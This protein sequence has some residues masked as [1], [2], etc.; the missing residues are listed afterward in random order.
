MGVFKGCKLTSFN[1]SSVAIHRHRHKSKIQ[2]TNTNTNIAARDIMM[3]D[4]E[5]TI[6]HSDM[7]PNHL[8]VLMAPAYKIRLRFKLT[9]EE[10]KCCHSLNCNS[11]NIIAI[12]FRSKQWQHSL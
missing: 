11:A 6:K 1:L 10:E 4:T 7:M 5:I 2:W 3:M 8:A 9:W 12:I